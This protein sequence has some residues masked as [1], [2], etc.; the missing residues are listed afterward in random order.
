MRYPVLLLATAMVSLVIGCSKSNSSKGGSGGGSG[1]GTTGGKVGGLAIAN[2]E[3]QGFM[4]ELSREWQKPIL[5]HFNADS[6]VI[7]Y[8][9]FYLAVTGYNY[10]LQD[11]LTGKIIQMGTGTGG[12]PT[13]TVYFKDIADTQVYNFSPDLS[14]LT[15]GSN[16]LAANQFY[17]SGLT[18]ITKPAASLAGS[19]WTCDSSTENNATKGSQWYPDINGTQFGS[20]SFCT[21]LRNGG[22]AEIGV[23]PNQTAVTFEYFQY[24]SR[25]YF[26]GYNEETPQAIPY[27]GIISNDGNTI[28]AD[29]EDFTY[30]RVPTYVQTFDYYGEAGNPPVMHRRT[31]N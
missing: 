29:T 12:G 18:R 6:T 19:F 16:G 25:V 31:T 23:V 22:Q 30:G 4:T 24:G 17:F 3:Y 13:V 7:D 21:Y 9:F 2:N 8:S 15:G 28:N 26:Y 27:W 14:G 10:F 20:N 1:G 5:V 11:S